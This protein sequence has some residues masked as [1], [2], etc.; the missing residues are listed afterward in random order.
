MGVVDDKWGTPSAFL[1]L[2]AFNLMAIFGLLFMTRNNIPLLAVAAVGIAGMTGGLQ[3]IQPSIVS[4]IYGRRNFSA[5]NG[6]LYAFESIFSS[7]GLSY[8]S[9]IMDTTGSLNAAYWG[10]AIMTALS[11]VF[12]V[13]LWKRN[14]QARDTLAAP[15]EGQTEVAI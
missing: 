12:I 6:W 7:F 9:I 8:M 4:Y 3:N 5:L 11:A 1:L 13:F 15:Q 14:P 10:M 2:C